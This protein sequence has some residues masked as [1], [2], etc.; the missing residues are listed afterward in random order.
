MAADDTKPTDRA[1]Q[2]QDRQQPKGAEVPSEKREDP[3]P[4]R[5]R[6]WASI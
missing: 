5:F 4:V 6:D 2:E 1:Q 3:K